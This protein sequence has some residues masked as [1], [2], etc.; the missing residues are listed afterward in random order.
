MAGYQAQA[1]HR[2]ITTT[3]AGE[4]TPLAEAVLAAAD[5]VALIASHRS[6]HHLLTDFLDPS[7]ADEA[8]PDLRTAELDLY[9]PDN[10][11]RPPYSREFLALYRAAQRA[12]NHRITAIAQERLAALRARG[13]GADEHCFTVQGTMADP[14]WLDPTI[15]PNDR[16]PGSSYL[17]DPRR[18]NTSPAGLARFTTARG[19]LSQWSLERAQF[20]AVESARSISKPVLCI[21]NTCDNACPTSHTRAIFDAVAHDDRELVAIEGANHYF[22]GESQ[23]SRLEEAVATVVDW[24]ARHDFTVTPDREA[25]H[26]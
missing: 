8:D 19:W 2:T 18:A 20:D 22:T 6:R 3:A 1:E 5:G 21:Y 13:R 12:R 14:R 15:D 16:V 7:I 11:E 10:P 25:A 26:R 24:A 4:P 23:R 9:D 17:G